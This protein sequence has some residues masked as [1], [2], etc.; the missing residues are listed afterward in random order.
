MSIKESTESKQPLRLNF[1][2]RSD[3]TS[4]LEQKYNFDGGIWQYPDRKPLEQL[5]A[6]RYGLKPSQVFCTNGG[7]EAIMI[8]MR[9]LKECSPLILPLPAFS[10]YVW[11]VESWQLEANLIEGNKDLTI[12]MDATLNALR[13][14]TN[15]VVIITRPNNPSGELISLSN[16]LEI[17]ETAKDNNSWVFLDEAYIEFSDE[18]SVACSL[19]AQND[20]PYNAQ[21][22][23]LVIL[24]TLSKAYGLAGIRL[25]Y[26]LGAEKLISE[27]EK[28]CAPFSVATPTLNIAMEALSKSNQE[29]V[30]NY[31]L[32]IRSNRNQLF[33]ELKSR[34]I[35]V[36]PSQANFLVLQLP[37]NQ[38]I[39]V[40][41][42]LARNGIMVRSFCDASLTNNLTNNMTNC[43]RVTIPF[44]MSKLSSLLKQA[45]YP[46]L[47]C[48]DMDGVL[49]DTSGSYD[50]TVIATVKKLSGTTIALDDIEQLKSKGGFNNDWVLSQQL[51]S[52]LGKEY[53]LEEVIKVFQQIYLGENND[54]LV[55]NEQVIINQSL[56]KLIK[57]STAAITN[58]SFAI[59]FAIVTG[60]PLIEA[61][62]GANFIGLEQLKLISLDC[63]EN[64]KPSP[65][66]IKKLQ[67]SY[68][69]FSWMCGDNP[70]DMQAANASNSLAIGIANEQN[71]QQALY[72][73][74]ADF[75]LNDI[76]EL[77]NWLCPLK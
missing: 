56:V 16:L 45:L 19:L 41:S 49:I 27:F 42:F 31:C 30:D 21:Y 24:R 11:G 68:S 29:D 25:G 4:P 54:G 75:V 20:D 10:Q 18:Q 7:D 66:G 8:L 33:N 3:F 73:A 47:I 5:L 63:V 70:D 57:D 39:A 37:I 22:D 52:N 71:K 55:Q 44:N 77:E 61:T 64:A 26:L 28:R 2:E 76:N 59:A 14:T 43:L 50:A 65:E 38:S 35:N 51:L 46:D 6:G 13:A 32:T 15:S 58:T 12:D 36:L 48:L 69:A 9:I 67:D 23:N 34:N 53:D 17:I 60:R 62:A 1:N 72:L 40:E 74:G